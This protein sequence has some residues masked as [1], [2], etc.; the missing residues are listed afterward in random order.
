MGYTLS[1]VRKYYHSTEIL[2]RILE[3]CGVPSCLASN[4]TDSTPRLTDSLELKRVLCSATAEYISAYGFRLLEVT[5][6][7]HASMKSHC[8]GWILDNGLDIH[9]SIWDRG[10]AIGALDVEYF[11]KN[12]PGEPYLAPERTFLLLEPIYQAILKMVHSYGIPLLV[13]TTGQGYNFD[14]F[15]KKDSPVY[16]DLVSLGYVERTLLHDYQ[17]PS[18]KRGRAVPEQDGKAFDAIGKLLEF[19]CYRIFMDLPNLGLSIP[20]VVG[21]VI[22]G[23]EKREA[24]SLDLSLYANPIHTRSVRCPFSVYSKHILKKQIVGDIVAKRVSYL[25]SIPRRTTDAELTLA[26]ALIIR[27]DMNR[28]IQ[29]AKEVNTAIPDQTEGFS[30]LISEYKRSALYAFHKEFEK[31]RQDGISAWPQTYD[32]FDLKSVPPCVAQPLRFPNPLLLQPT[33]IRHITRILMAM[34]WHPKHIAGL[35]HSKYARDYGWEVNFLRYD[36]NRWA[37]VWVR[38]YAGMILSRIDGLTD[39]NCVS[40]QEKGEAWMGM[41]YCPKPWCGFNLAEYRGLLLRS[42]S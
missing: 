23:N 21:D 31:T 36:A 29:W 10:N 35:I 2:A 19:I 25:F 15:V 28:A 30:A 18:A 24:I 42:I 9:R 26:N 6:K 1:D 33:S 7:D 20:V 38:I 37:N 17:H 14:I 27:K 34:G 22:C 32:R 12:F 4:V 8:V 5:K 41:K 11:S 39:L 16:K 3:F 13:V 40:H